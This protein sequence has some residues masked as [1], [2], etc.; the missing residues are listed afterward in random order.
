MVLG[1]SVRIQHTAK[2]L[3]V[4]FCLLSCQEEKQEERKSSVEDSAMGN[5][6]AEAWNGS[7]HGTEGRVAVG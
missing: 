3:W 5:V 7:Q 2:N 6:E 1:T 4:L